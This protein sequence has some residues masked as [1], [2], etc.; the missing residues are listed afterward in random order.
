MMCEQ[1]N[2]ISLNILYLGRLGA[3]DGNLEIN[4]DIINCNVRYGNNGQQR[5]ADIHP[6]A[7]LRLSAT[8]ASSSVPGRGVRAIVRAIACV[9][10]R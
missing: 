4:A 5:D 9:V 7:I 2:W 10:G 3:V 1:M 8:C 6:T